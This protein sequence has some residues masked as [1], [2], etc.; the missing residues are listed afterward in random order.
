M[1]DEMK[2]NILASSFTRLW[3]VKNYEGRIM[4][5]ERKHSGFVIYPPLAGEEL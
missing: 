2:G 4:N 3:R 5:D 1:N